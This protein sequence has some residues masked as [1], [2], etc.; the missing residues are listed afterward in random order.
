MKTKKDGTT[1]FGFLLCASILRSISYEILLGFLAA[2]EGEDDSLENCK[3]GSKAVQRVMEWGRK[4]EKERE[5]ERGREKE[6]KSSMCTSCLVDIRRRTI[7]EIDICH[8]N[9]TRYERPR[10]K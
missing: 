8:P 10:I 1:P 6:Q 2:Q 3:E 7:L 9:V 5:R 4:K